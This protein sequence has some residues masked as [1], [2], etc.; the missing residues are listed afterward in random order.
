MVCVECEVLGR[1]EESE[2]AREDEFGKNDM[3][4]P[5]QECGV[6]LGDW[7]LDNFF[8]HLN[9]VTEK[10]LFIINCQSL[11]LCQWPF[12]FGDGYKVSFK[13]W[14]AEAGSAS[15]GETTS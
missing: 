5:C 9:L 12:C 10:I 2:G 14:K 13:K 4:T 1:R 11:V 6:H 8:L 3:T 15:L 7:R